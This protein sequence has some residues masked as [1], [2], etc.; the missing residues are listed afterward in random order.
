MGKSA[1]VCGRH[2]ELSRSMR[3]RYGSGMEAQQKRCGSGM[4]VMCKCPGNISVLWEPRTMHS[5]EEYL[6]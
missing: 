5:R 2:W 6:R 3:E 1:E 4:E